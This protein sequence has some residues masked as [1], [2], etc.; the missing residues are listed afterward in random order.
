MYSF[1]ESFEKQCQ[2]AENVGFESHDVITKKT[3][4][5]GLLPN[6]RGKL[7]Q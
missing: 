6:I 3:F 4:I 1:I 2:W 7:Q 5:D